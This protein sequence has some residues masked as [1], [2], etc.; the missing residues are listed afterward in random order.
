MLQNNK[1]TS[2]NGLI[3]S[4]NLSKLRCSKHGIRSRAFSTCECDLKVTTYC[5]W[6]VACIAYKPDFI[7]VKMI[8]WS[9][10]LKLNTANGDTVAVMLPNCPIYTT[11]D[12]NGRS[13]NVL[14]A[15][16]LYPH[17]NTIMRFTIISMRRK[18]ALI[19]YFS[20]KMTHWYQI[21]V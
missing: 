14:I 8:N 11:L 18:I 21:T 1:S 20:Q 15:I 4:F 17:R 16:T 5:C 2:N 12:R 19:V 9:V 3:R 6:I 13:S 10:M 7:S